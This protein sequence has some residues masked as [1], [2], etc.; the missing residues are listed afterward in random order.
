[1]GLIR[2]ATGAVGS[3]MGDQW[4]EF[5]YHDTMPDTLLVSKGQKQATK[6][7]V[8][9]NRSD[10]II[11][12]GSGIAI[13]EGQCMIVVEQGKVMDV[14]A[15]PGQYTWNQSSEPSVFSGELGNSVVNTL[16]TIG[17]RFTFGGSTGKD[18][19]VYYINIKELLNNKFGTAV[20]V[21]LRVIDTN[22]GLDADISLR[23]NGI[24]SYKITNPL[25]FYTN[26][27]GNVEQEFTRDKI[28]S[29]LKSEFL[30]ALQPA[31][32]QMSAMGLR[33]SAIPGHTEHLCQAL[34]TALSQKWEKL[35]GLKV[36]SVAIN[37]I[38]ASQEDEDMIKQLQRTA[39]MRDPGMAGAALVNAQAEAMKTAS[40][41]EGGSMTG[42]L[43]LGLAQQAGGMNLHSTFANPINQA[44]VAS[45][46]TPLSPAGWVCACAISNTGKFCAECGKPKPSDAK[47]T[48]VCGTE[49]AGKFCSECGKVKAEETTWACACGFANTGRFCSECGTAKS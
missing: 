39:V 46:P 36:V 20:P 41:N 4:L 29:Q 48:C 34:N 35:R 5:F 31:F 33:Y 21:P 44:A 32:A 42:F 27:T 9:A 23:C 47:W 14:C 15:E 19:R 40:A 18:Q 16:K 10:N 7:S 6:R 30:S 26:V 8:N 11:S 45:T 37:A 17:R 12:N 24:F 1:M 43:G 13:N 2:A 3:A 25:L 38:S 49:N 28:D 22:I